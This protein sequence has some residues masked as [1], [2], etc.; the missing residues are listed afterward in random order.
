MDTLLLRAEYFFDFNET[1]SENQVKVKELHFDGK[2]IQWRHGLIKTNG[3]VAIYWGQLLTSHFNIP[4]Y[5][6]PL[7]D[8]QNLRQVDFLQDYLDVLYHPEG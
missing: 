5:D 4:A 8:W 3:D 2:A 1:A 7:L 6:D